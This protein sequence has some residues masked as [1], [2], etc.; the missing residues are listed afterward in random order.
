MNFR[1][2]QGLTSVFS[3]ED[4]EIQC[5]TN[6][7]HLKDTHV[8]NLSNNQQDLEPCQTTIS[9]CKSHTIGDRTFHTYVFPTEQLKYLANL[10]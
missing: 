8:R 1:I 10:N 6:I 3:A 2:V 9:T 4:F 5:N 7:Q